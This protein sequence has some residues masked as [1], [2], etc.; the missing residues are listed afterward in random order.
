M[1]FQKKKALAIG[2]VL[3]T[4]FAISGL[5]AAHA[6][7]MPDTPSSEE[8]LEPFSDEATLAMGASGDEPQE[9]A[10]MPEFVAERPP[11]W[12]HGHEMS[13]SCPESPRFGHGHMHHC[14]FTMALMHAGVDLSDEQVEKLHSLHNQ[15]LD[16][17]DPIKAQMKS[18]R[19]QFFDIIGADNVDRKKAQDVTAELNQQKA[20]FATLMSD[21]MV[22]V[23]QVLTAE[24]RKKIRLSCERM[25]LGPLGHKHGPKVEEET[26][27]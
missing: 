2:L 18:L 8:M 26:K 16:K 20:K 21:H 3:P 9:V 10:A 12:G 24:Q 19:R 17:A 4:A 23:S 1:L 27:S 22:D 5:L 7:S 15:F 13:E 25:H 11:H 6:Q 14:P